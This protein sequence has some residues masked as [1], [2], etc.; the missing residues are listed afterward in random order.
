MLSRPQ[1]TWA[2]PYPE[3]AAVAWHQARL[4]RRLPD[5]WREQVEEWRRAAQDGEALGER[6]RGQLRRLLGEDVLAELGLARRRTG[7]GRT[8]SRGPGRLLSD[9]GRLLAPRVRRL[10]VLAALARSSGPLEP[11]LL[12][13]V[14]DDWG[15]DLARPLSPHQPATWGPGG[16]GD[17]PGSPPGRAAA[18]AGPG[19]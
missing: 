17:Q 7:G 5:A 3:P 9:A 15:R 11:V 19:R 12:R 2:C 14:A 6:R 13:E 18:A 4:L 1:L 16:R 10:A 8:G